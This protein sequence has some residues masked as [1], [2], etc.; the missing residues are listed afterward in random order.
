M[1]DDELKVN[2]H[3]LPNEESFIFFNWV[4]L[5]RAIRIVVSLRAYDMWTSQIVHLSMLPSHVNPLLSHFIPNVVIL[6]FS[7]HLDET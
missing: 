5:D 4:S 7:I 1:V 3:E 2:D 6:G